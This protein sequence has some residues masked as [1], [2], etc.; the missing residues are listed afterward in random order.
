MMRSPSRPRS[1]PANRGEVPM[2]L[3]GRHTWRVAVLAAS[4]FAILGGIAYAT[5][6]DG[7]GIY[8]ACM[9]NKVGTIRLIDPSLPA[10]SLM[11]H[12]TALETQITWNQQGQPGPQGL[13]GPKGDTGAQGPQ[14]AKGDTGVPGAQGPQGP[15]GTSVT[16]ASEP[17]GSNCAYGGASF[18]SAS[19]TTYACNGAPGAQGTQGAT[20]DTGPP[21][22]TGPSGPVDAWVA[23]GNAGPEPQSVSVTVPPGSYVVHADATAENDFTTVL[24]AECLLSIDTSPIPE[25]LDAAEVNL[26]GLAANGELNIQ[27]FGTTTDSATSITESCHGAPSNPSGE[28]VLFDNLHIDAISANL[29]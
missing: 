26:P 18:A 9:L 20:G 12:C 24:I 14:G 29:H 17:P 27:G 5:I 13:Q 15:V 3:V 21:G 10:S 8:S 16:S 6:P 25:G 4:M 1:G 22:P 11:S 2:T 7:K 19:P 23:R 28:D